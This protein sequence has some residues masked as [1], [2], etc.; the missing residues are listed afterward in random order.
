MNDN[1]PPLWFIYSVTMAGI[2]ANTMLTPNIPDILRDLGQ[3]ESRAGL[4]VAAGPLPGIVV[5]PIIGIVADRFGRRKALLPCLWLFGFMGIASALAPTF[6]TLLIARLLQGAGSAGL[7]NLAVVLIGDN[8]EGN[9]RSTLVGRNSAVLTLGLV[10]APSV[11][12]LIAEVTNWRWSLA[13]TTVGLLVAATGIRVL[14]VHRPGATVTVRQQLRDTAI[15]LRS[16]VVLTVI[17][18]V[19][20]LFVVIFGVFLTTFPLHL[21]SEFG[22]GPGARGLVLSSPSIGATL[23]A[24]NLGR[25]RKAFPVRG[26]LVASSTLIAVA[27]AGIGLAPTVLVIILA[28]LLYGLGDGAI[29]PTLQDVA[30]SVA[31]P[32]RRGVVMAAWVSSARLGQTVGALAAAPLFGATSTGFT[33]VLGGGLFATVALLFAVAPLADART[34]H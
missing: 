28:A 8:W 2:L 26:I 14:P 3:P 4:L 23:V 19:F 12:G 25:I 32:E 10:L 15:E 31:T 20:L 6:E 9:E 13:L 7:I 30:T 24:F 1:R 34:S 33:M 16:P 27:A 21:E 29:I 22:L 11:S 17:G 18:G 5:A